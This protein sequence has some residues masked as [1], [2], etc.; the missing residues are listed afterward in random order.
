MWTKLSMCLGKLNFIE[1]F[2]VWFEYSGKTSPKTSKQAHQC[3]QLQP[4][5]TRSWSTWSLW[6]CGAVSKMLAWLEALKVDGIRRLHA[7]PTVSCLPICVT[8]LQSKISSGNQFSGI[9]RNTIG[10]SHRCRH[11]H[12]TL[13]LWMVYVIVAYNYIM[14]YT[15]YIFMNI[16]I[17]IFF[18]VRSSLL[19]R[20]NFPFKSCTV[21][22]KKKSTAIKKKQVGTMASSF[23][24]CFSWCLMPSS[25]GNWCPNVAEKKIRDIS[26]LHPLGMA[27][28]YLFPDLEKLDLNKWYPWDGGPKII[29]PI[30]LT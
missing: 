8:F 26:P 4:E 9:F 16:Y 2:D 6:S 3:H 24:A 29:N 22:T 30:Y 25:F 20:E 19:L 23:S 27:M 5:T 21:F 17:I 12:C 10:L 13:M 18:G 28:K 11:C 15:M 7:Y 14:F 1:F